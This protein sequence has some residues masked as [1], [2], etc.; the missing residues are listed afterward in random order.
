[1]I[2][3]ICSVFA[4][5]SVFQKA[6]VYVGFKQGILEAESLFESPRYTTYLTLEIG[7]LFS[8]YQVLFSHMWKF[9]CEA[10]Q[11]CGIKGEDIWK[12]SGIA[13]K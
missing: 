8:F 13:L 7:K 10:S 3:S 9:L 4:I 2:V 6:E 12:Y 1:M 5:V 11:N